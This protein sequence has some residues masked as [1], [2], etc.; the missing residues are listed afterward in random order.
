MG[1][2]AG[3]C[4]TGTGI[5]GNRVVTSGVETETNGT[6]DAEEEAMGLSSRVNDGTSTGEAD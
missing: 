2:E 1:I 4:I 3:V 6:T 5:A